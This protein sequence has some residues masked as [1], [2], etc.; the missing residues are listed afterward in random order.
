LSL[1]KFKFVILKSKTNLRGRFA[2][3]Y[4]VKYN[5]GVR[6][7]GAQLLHLIYMQIKSLVKRKRKLNMT[8]Q[9]PIS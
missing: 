1:E 3:R 5:F 8:S 6:I 9:V 4:V 2:K 7:F